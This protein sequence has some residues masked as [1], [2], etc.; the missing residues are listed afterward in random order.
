VPQAAALSG[1]PRL[2]DLHD[3]LSPLS[4]DTDPSPADWIVESLTDFGKSVS[5]IVPRGF[6]AYVRVFHHAHRREADEVV[7]VRWNEIAAAKRR[8]PHAGMQ[9]CALTRGDDEYADQPGLDGQPPRTGS[10]PRSLIPPLVEVLSAHTEMQGRCRFGVWHGFGDL[11]TALR[12]A[13]TF[14]TRGREYHLLSG[15]LGDAGEN[16]SEISW[17]HRSASIWWPDDHAWC[18]ATEV[19]L[20]TTYI[21]CSEACRDDLLARPELEAYEIDPSYG[22]DSRSDTL[23]PF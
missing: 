15:S 11:R 10:L 2:P 13:P 20:R 7:H 19:D 18:V 8:I 17:G 9:L 4:L 3:R 16:L 22:I 1:L 5:S 23:N 12:E 14:E 21:A 6:P